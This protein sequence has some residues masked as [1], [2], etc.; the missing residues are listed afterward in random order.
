MVLLSALVF[1]QCQHFK[2]HFC[3]A[4]IV[5]VNSGK[6]DEERQNSPLCKGSCPSS[7]HSGLR[8]QPLVSFRPFSVCPCLKGPRSQLAP[9]WVAKSFHPLYKCQPSIYHHSER[10]ACALPLRMMTLI[11]SS[12]CCLPAQATRW[13][14]TSCGGSLSASQ[15]THLDKGLLLRPSIVMNESQ[16]ES[17]HG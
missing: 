10:T 9:N 17:P 12:E 14:Q 6:A 1:L 5:G 3:D 7:A 4:L 15:L 8:A 11:R 16:T 13:G 2:S